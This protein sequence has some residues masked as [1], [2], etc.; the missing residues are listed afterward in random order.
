MKTQ[1]QNGT[2]SPIS[3]DSIKLIRAHL[4]SL[5]YGQVILTVQDGKLIQIEKSE[6][7]RLK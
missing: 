1:E 6:K 3:E 2:K 5:Q 4:E 7:M